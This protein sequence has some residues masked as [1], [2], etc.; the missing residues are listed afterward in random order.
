MASHLVEILYFDG[1]PHARPTIDLTRKVVAEA[2]VEAD[3]REVIVANEVDAL[4]LCFLGSPTVRV[5]GRDVDPDTEG[6][7]DYGIQCRVYPTEV[8][9]DGLPP[10]TWIRAALRRT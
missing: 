1:C 10:A 4:R 9:L 3:V 5:D 7:D 6:R 2:G 8:G